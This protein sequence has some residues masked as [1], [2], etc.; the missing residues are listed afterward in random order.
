MDIE[1]NGMPL[2]EFIKDAAKTGCESITALGGSMTMS[3]GVTIVNGG[4]VAI[5]RNGKRY[6]LR[7]EKIIKK[8][9]VWY[10]D[11]KAVD[12]AQLGGKY[13]EEHVVNVEITGNVQSL[14]TT[15]GNVTVHGDCVSVDTGSGDVQCENAINVSTGSGDVHCGQVAG[16]V[17]TGSGN[18]YRK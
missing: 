12:W 1:I 5:T 16:N 8:G 11:G 10:V 14:H 2:G 13:E 17:S 7:G 15:M 18:V 4:S 6:V 3:G 9:G